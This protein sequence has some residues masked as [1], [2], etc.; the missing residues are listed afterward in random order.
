MIKIRDLEVAFNG[1]IVLSIPSADFSG[2]SVILGPNGAG[3]TTLLKTIV[4][5]YKPL[6]GYIEADGVDIRRGSAYRLLSAN[7]ETVYIMP[8]V[9]LNDL[10][11]IYCS[12]F[13]CDIQNVKQF[14]S[15]IK[16]KARE[17]WKLSAGEKKWISTILALS[18][19]TRITLLDEP[20]EDLDP[21][22]VRKLVEE[23]REASKHKQIV[24]TLHSIHLLREFED[25]DLFF[26]FDGALYGSIRSR[27]VFDTEIVPG[28]DPKAL[29]IF[30]MHGEEYSLVKSGAGK[31]VPL[32][33]I[34]DLT[35]L[36]SRSKL[37]S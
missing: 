29:L 19:D 30:R 28:R 31:G 17:F 27:E 37:G 1:R 7:I 26:M 18:A 35:Q 24:L 15:Y 32:R 22:L 25:W 16:P 36:Y 10:L 23:I 12:A 20:F 13:N 6:H 3:K 21:W 5:L 4:G 33:E 8:G 9:R 11:E 34:N 14:L 2:N